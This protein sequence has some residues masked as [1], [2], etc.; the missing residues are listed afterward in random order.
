MHLLS[1]MSPVA[2]RILENFKSVMD[3]GAAAYARAEGKHLV[4]RMV[5]VT[6]YAAVEWVRELVNLGQT[7]L[8]ESRPQ[9]LVERAGQL[10]PEIEWH[11]IGTLQ[12]NKVR[13]VLPHVSLIHSVD[14]LK[15][16]ERIDA[17]ATEL[18][19]K[20]R[21]L[22]QVNVSGEASKQ[23]FGPDDLLEN[24]ITIAAR[25]HVTIA[26]LMTM[27]PLVDD[28]EL[29]RPTFVGLRQL[30]DELRRRTADPALLPELSMGMSNDFEIAIEEG[31]TLYR[32]GSLLFEGLETSGDEGS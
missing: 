15:L 24:W 13:A 14:S 18:G 32:I 31:T 23:G 6:K 21:V 26:G 30:R 22:L 20:P 3:R 16:L 8:G 1:I 25:Q 2:S 10:G 9:Q 4:P 5:A 19:L 29:A 11:L 27:A 7:T 17:V 12:R 28:P